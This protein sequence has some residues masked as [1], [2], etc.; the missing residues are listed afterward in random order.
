MPKDAKAEIP[1]PSG[2]GGI[3][4]EGGRSESD[5]RMVRTR[6]EPPPFR[7][8]VVARL[9]HLTRR[10]IRVTFTGSD[11]EGL[12]VDHPAASVRL[13]LPSPGSH[14]SNS[15]SPLAAQQPQCPRGPAHADV[16]PPSPS[17]EWGHTLISQQLRDPTS[18][19]T[20]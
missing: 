2:S 13:L 5:Q 14:R 7:H 8:M 17:R 11:L 12:T 4:S 1:G 9:D 10:M 18:V 19:P 6:R 16:P 3:K 20:A 15:V